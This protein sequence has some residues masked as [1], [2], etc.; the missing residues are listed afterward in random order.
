MNG[1]RREALESEW[2][3]RATRAG[4]RIWAVRAGFAGMVLLLILLPLALALVAFFFENREAESASNIGLLFG[5]AEDMFR[6]N[7]LK[8]QADIALIL[9][10]LALFSAILITAI[11]GLVAWTETL[12][13]RLAVLR[14]RLKPLDPVP[15]SIE[16][17]LE[18]LCTAMGID[19]QRVIP[20]LASSRNC[21]PGVIQSRQRIHLLL[22]LGFLLLSDSDPECAKA[23]LAHEFGHVVQADT[24]LWRTAEAF[25]GAFR[26]IILPFL[27]FELAVT[28][29]VSPFQL[30]NRP[31]LNLPS[32]AQHAA[33]LA[34]AA[35][36]MLLNLL[37]SWTTCCFVLKARRNSEKL[38]DMAG[39]I[40]GGEDAMVRVNEGALH[41]PP[42]ERLYWV[43]EHVAGADPLPPF[44]ADSSRVGWRV[45]ASAVVLMLASSVAWAAMLALG[46]AQ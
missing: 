43:K 5:G 9:F 21:T 44:R 10:V 12:D 14:G 3:H 20:R 33:T 40:Y 28:L 17:L 45:L 11:V 6:A 46:A 27:L 23:M 41:P 8:A 35:S 13:F 30:G 25:T 36:Y 1:G 32:L 38:A 16:A 34:M 22:P 42:R 18:A 37:I 29:L 19:R 7:Q 15:P 39:L 24:R 4:R 2:R 31:E 26:R